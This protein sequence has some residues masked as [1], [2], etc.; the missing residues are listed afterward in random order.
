MQVKAVS[1]TASSET[2]TTFNG[3]RR[4]STETL[5]ATDFTTLFTV[6]STVATDNGEILYCCTLPVGNVVYFLAVKQNYTVSHKKRSQL[7][8]VCNFVKNQRILMQFSLLDLTMND[9]R[10][11]VNFTHLT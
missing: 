1:K 4:S 5:H 9:T 2:F 8:F 10:E 7:I 6:L 3:R 11:G